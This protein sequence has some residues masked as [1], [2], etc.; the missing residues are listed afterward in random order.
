MDLIRLIFQSNLSPSFC[1]F[2]QQFPT[3]FLELRLEA[4]DGDGVCVLVGR[5]IVGVSAV[6]DCESRP[7]QAV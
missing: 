1:N 4:A 2:S 5:S 7:R 6:P 3:F